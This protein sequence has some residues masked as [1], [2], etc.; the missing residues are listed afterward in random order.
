MHVVWFLWTQD[1][2]P[3]NIHRQIVQRV[4]Y[5]CDVHTTSVEVVRWKS[6]TRMEVAVSHQQSWMLYVERWVTDPVRAAFIHQFSRV[7]NIGHGHVGCP[8]ACSARMPDV[9]PAYVLRTLKC[10]AHRWVG[11]GLKPRLVISILWNSKLR[12]RSGFETRP[13]PVAAGTLEISLYDMAG[14]WTSWKG[15]ELMSTYYRTLCLSPL[16]YV[17]L[18]ETRKR[19]VTF[20]CVST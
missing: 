1:P 5:R 9:W 8:W 6:W 10:M 19:S 7:S 14:A 15:T 3:M 16:R 13:F 17:F 12:F 11:G 18:K 2:E 20:L 4:W